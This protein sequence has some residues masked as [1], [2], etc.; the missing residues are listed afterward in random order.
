MLVYMVV[1]TCITGVHGC[2]Y[3]YKGVQRG[4]TDRVYKLSMMRCARTVSRGRGGN[5]YNIS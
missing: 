5:H 3:G 1:Y 2:M 4:Y